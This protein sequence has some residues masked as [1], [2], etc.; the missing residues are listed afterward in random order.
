MCRNIVGLRVCV[1]QAIGVVPARSD[2]NL[3]GLAHQVLV[4]DA[5]RTLAGSDV[6]EY[7][8]Q[9]AVNS[10]INESGAESVIFS[11]ANR[12]GCRIAL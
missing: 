8:G 9:A 2:M 5:F 3:R 7:L 1:R 6:G 12:N 10:N 11:A 4:M